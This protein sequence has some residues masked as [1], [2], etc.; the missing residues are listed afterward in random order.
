MGQEN[1]DRGHQIYNWKIIVFD[2]ALKSIKIIIAFKMISK[3]LK[4]CNFTGIIFKIEYFEYF[5]WI[6]KKLFSFKMNIHIETYLFV[7]GY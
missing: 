3:P 1:S 6:L 2:I 5:Y 4:P 7:S